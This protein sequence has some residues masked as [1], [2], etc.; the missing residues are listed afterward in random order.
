MLPA[1]TS[2]ARKIYAPLNDR[3]CIHP[4]A[5]N[6]LFL[7][8]STARLKKNSQALREIPAATVENTWPA[9]IERNRCTWALAPKNIQ[10]QP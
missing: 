3:P 7:Q 4:L 2:C 6:P 5:T 1:Q 9:T 8:N 10:C